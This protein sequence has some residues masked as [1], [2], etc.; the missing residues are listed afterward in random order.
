MPKF[1]RQ[2]FRKALERRTGLCIRRGKNY[3]PL[4]WSRVDWPDPLTALNAGQGRDVLLTI[5]LAVCRFQRMHGAIAYKTGQSPLI[6]VVQDYLAGRCTAYA[7]SVLES[8]YA[9]FQP[10]AP[11]E[12]LRLHD[13]TSHW[14]KTM[15]PYAA[16]FPWEDTSPDRRIAS[17]KRIEY[18]QGHEHGGRLDLSNGYKHFGPT[19]REKGELE[20]RRL[21]AVAESIRQQGFRVDPHSEKNLG[22]RLLIWNEDHRFLQDG[23]GNHRMAALAALGYERAVMQLRADFVV[24]RSEVD[25]W[26]GVRQGWF[27]ADEALQIFD[28]IFWGSV[29][30]SK[31]AHGS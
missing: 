31:S 4:D 7:G 15:P 27:T 13:V 12:Y 14:L 24:R 26:P 11:A 8:F 19:C 1:Y 6:K 17:K 10:R 5:P 21:I 2:R 30:F 3:W 23:S 20:F 9:D 18:K 25:W 22:V 16:F 29:A 28:R